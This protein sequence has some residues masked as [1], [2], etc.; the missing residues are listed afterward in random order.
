MSLATPSSSDV[1]LSSSTRDAYANES[2]DDDPVSNYER[3]E[4]IF[5]EDPFAQND[6]EPYVLLIS[7]SKVFLMLT[8][9][10]NK[11]ILQAQTETTCSL[12][13]IKRLLW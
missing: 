1:G 7:N 2:E 6:T 3:D 13:P 12:Q 5:A 11:N 4:A 10:K 8:G 9:Y